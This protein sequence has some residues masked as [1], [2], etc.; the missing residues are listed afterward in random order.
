[1][2]AVRFSIS[3]QLGSALDDENENKKD[4]ADGMRILSHP[5]INCEQFR[6][7]SPVYYD[8]KCQFNTLNLR[9]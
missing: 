1:M 7:I 8:A 3:Q 2:F 4:E 6:V 9:N 5:M